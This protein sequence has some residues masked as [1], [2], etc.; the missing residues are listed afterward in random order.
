MSRCAVVIGVNKTGDLPVLQAAVSGAKEF[1]DWATN[2]GIEVTLLI[3]DNGLGVSLSDVKKAI[4]TFVQ[5]KIFSQLIVFFSGHG[6]LRAPDY[7]L[8][9]LSGAPDDA[10]DA[11]N[12]PGSIWLARNAGIPHVIVISDACRSRPNTSRLSQIQGGVIFPNESPRTPRPAVD[13]FYATLPGD[14]ALE[15]PPPDAVQNYRGIF[16]ECLLKGLK[17][18]VPDVI[19]DIGDKHLNETRWVIPSWELKPYLEEEVPEVAASINIKLQQDPDIRV[20]SHPPNFLAEV[21]PPSTPAVPRTESRQEQLSVSFRHVV[22]S[23]KSDKFFQGHIRYGDLPHDTSD[24]AKRS[25]F[26]RAIDRLLDA[27]GRESFETL[28]GFT[29][30]GAAP[31]RA[32][33]TGSQ[34]DLFEESGAYQIRIHERQDNAQRPQSLLVQFSNG[35]G[36]ALAVLPGFIGTI[37]VEEGRV[38]NVTYLPSRHTGKFNEYQQ[39][40]SE[41]EKR[42]AYV[43]VA[44]RNGSLRFDQGLEAHDAARYLRVM[45]GVDPTLG[46][47]VSYAYAQAGDFEGVDSV[48]QYMSYEPEPILFDV[49]LIANKLPKP[50]QISN[51]QHPVAPFCPM[52]TQGWALLKPYEELIPTAVRE[53][54]R[55]LIPGLWTTFGTKGL[56][57]L[58]S[59]IDKGELV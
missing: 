43:A 31:M 19:V 21:V 13:V 22:Q 8:W 2:Q 24:V 4:R 20:E 51:Y 55:D 46:L 49:A 11:V 18:E 41:I 34:C 44:A 36:I 38:V 27:K 23:L 54:G 45:K 59:S 40:A 10:D 3:D 29:V 37:V 7:E 33:A 25:D 12:V 30:V 57:I 5:K 58:W 50:K 53:A 52:L 48:Y 6:I 17:G 32:V 42:R 47:Y 16:T 39:V 26:A 28:T 9:L 35:Q 1:A 15:A 14:P 56:E